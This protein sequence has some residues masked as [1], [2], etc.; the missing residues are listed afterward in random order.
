MAAVQMNG[1]LDE[2]AKARGGAVF[3]RRGA[4]PPQGGRAAWGGAA[5]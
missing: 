4:T 5:G 3:A 2:G 1:R